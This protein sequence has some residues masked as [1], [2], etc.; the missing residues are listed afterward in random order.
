MGEIL[1][2]GRSK[3]GA[4]RSAV[5][6]IVNTLVGAVVMGGCVVGAAFIGEYVFGETGRDYRPFAL[7][8]AVLMSVCGFALSLWN[9]WW[10]F[11]SLLAAAAFLV[12]ILTIFFIVAGLFPSNT[13]EW[14]ILLRY[15]VIP[16]VI[17]SMLGSALKWWIWRKR[18]L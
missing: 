3:P 18:S 1:D 5:W 8:V 9:K 10:I 17:G 13:S 14:F 11:D 4:R 12:G 16:W 6:F 7:S 2:Y 15:T